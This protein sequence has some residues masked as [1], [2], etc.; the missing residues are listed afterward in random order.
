MLI[1][2]AF[3]GAVIQEYKES[4]DEINDVTWMEVQLKNGQSLALSY[5]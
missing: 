4:S 1:W 3:S 2:N 5:G